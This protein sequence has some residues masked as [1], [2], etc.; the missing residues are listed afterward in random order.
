MKVAMETPRSVP[1]VRNS[2]F[3]GI[4]HPGPHAVEVELACKKK[5]GKDA[6]QES[7]VSD[8]VHDKGLLPGNGLFFIFIPEADE[9]VGAEA[10]A[11]PPDEHEQ[12]VGS[13]SP[14]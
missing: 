7:E 2:A 11:F 1:L 9:E 5:E 8:P 3:S 13:P 12:D 14:G 6:D 10:H 4:G